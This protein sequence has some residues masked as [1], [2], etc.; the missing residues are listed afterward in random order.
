LSVSQH[1]LPELHESLP[2]TLQIC[3]GSLQAFPWF[4][5]RPNSSVGE[6]FVQTIG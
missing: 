4:P 6:F 3:P 2:P 1:L 5:Q